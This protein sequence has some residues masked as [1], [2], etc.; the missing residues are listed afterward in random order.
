MSRTGRTPLPSAAFLFMPN[1][2]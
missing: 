2:K 1:S